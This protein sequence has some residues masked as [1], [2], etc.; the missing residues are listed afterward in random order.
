MLKKLLNKLVGAP[1]SPD[2]LQAAIEKVHENSAALIME[3]GGCAQALTANSETRVEV[4][5]VCRSS[6]K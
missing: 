2:K 4:K 5:K 3:C 6:R 1:A